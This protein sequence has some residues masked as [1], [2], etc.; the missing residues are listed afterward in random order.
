MNNRWFKKISFTFSKSKNTKVMSLKI[1][2]VGLILALLTRC[3]IQYTTPTTPVSLASDRKAAIQ[4]Q[5]KE[6]F[7]KD[8]AV[9]S[10]IAWGQTKTLKPLI[11]KELD[12]LYAIKYRM[13]REGKRDT[14]LDDQI[15]LQRQIALN[16]TAQILY[17]EDHLFGVRKNNKL[18]IYS[19]IFETT[20]DH[21][22]RNSKI[23][24]SQEIDPKLIEEYKEYTFMESFINPGFA[25]SSQENNFYA[26]FKSKEN[27]L[28]GSARDTFL[29][30]TLQIMQLARIARSLKTTDLLKQVVTYHVNGDDFKGVSNLNFESMEEIVTKIDEKDFVTGY[31]VI[32][33]FQKVNDGMTTTYRYFVEMNDYYELV[34]KALI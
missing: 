21:V 22:I 33:T 7:E 10:D 13:E 25:A 29:N 9:Y 34:R 8:S 26:K 1:L 20:K 27:S 31:Q 18:S 6:T 28:I 24:D 4:K 16:D 11:Y 3:G 15:K 30:H 19:A 14:E 17:Q 23:K 32:Y 5:L 2:F 12:S